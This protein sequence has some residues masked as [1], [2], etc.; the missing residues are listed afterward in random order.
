[1]RRL[2]AVIL[3]PL[4]LVFAAAC[5]SSDDS[6]ENAGLPAVSGEFGKKPT[7]TAPEGQ[8][9][10]TQLQSKT[11]SEG[12]GATVKKGDLL[13]A[14]YLGQTWRENK[15]F[16]N[17]YDRG[18]PAG[19]VIGAGQV[20]KGW[21]ESLVGV[22]AGSRVELIIPPDKGYGAQGQPQAGIKGDD[23]LVFV[24]DLVASYDKKAGGEADAAPQRL[25]AGLPAVTGDLG[26]QPKI[27]VPKGSK[28]PAKASKVLVAQGSG[29][30][31]EKGAL[32]VTQ[33]E[34]VSWAGKTLGSTWQQGAPQGVGVGVKGQPSPFDQ[35]AG[36]PVGSRVLLLLPPQ[37][38]GTPAKDSIAAVIDIVAQHS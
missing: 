13:V 5:G 21:D 25:D 22:K 18:A 9:P 29:P 26:G 37:G 36:V 19:F 12:D 28:P 8:Q 15:V 30:A 16:D 2:L 23:T 33:F 32:V 3:L 4:L 20:I 17:S 24:V 6:A 10:A 38:G 7:V 35:L 31:V 14:N 27:A 34:A 1:M 11:L